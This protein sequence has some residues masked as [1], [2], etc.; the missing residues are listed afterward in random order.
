MATD[1]G[2]QHGPQST[3]D[4]Q[5]SDRFQQSQQRDDRSY[6]QQGSGNGNNSFGVGPA[7]PGFS[8]NFPGMPNGFQFPP[9]F[10]FPTAPGQPP[11]PGAP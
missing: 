5:Q 2:G 10:V 11:P 9:G 8:F 1:K 7:V 3:R 6:S 4:N